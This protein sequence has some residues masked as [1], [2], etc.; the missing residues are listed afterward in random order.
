MK[1]AR[2]LIVLLLS[3]LVYLIPTQVRANLGDMTCNDM[4]GCHGAA[5]CGGPGT[6]SACKITCES[7][8]EVICITN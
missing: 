3:L 7:G 4:S 6:K 8:A 1:T 2:V 5:S